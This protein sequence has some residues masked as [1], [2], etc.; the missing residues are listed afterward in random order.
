MIHVNKVYLRKTCFV[1]GLW[2]HLVAAVWHFFKSF[3]QYT[4]LC[5]FF[6]LQKLQ[7]SNNI[8]NNTLNLL[9]FYLYHMLVRYFL[10]FFGSVISD[11]VRT[12]CVF[13]V[14]IGI[15]YLFFMMSELFLSQYSAC[16]LVTASFAALLCTSR[17]LQAIPRKNSVSPVHQW[18]HRGPQY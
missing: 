14:F 17:P 5:F 8:T 18:P 7:S 16:Y 15:T 3:S 10:S 12:M 13:F 4:F 11:N 1:L 2:W 6:N 9:L